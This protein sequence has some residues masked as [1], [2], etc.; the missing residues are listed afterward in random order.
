M[1]RASAGGEARLGSRG[2]TLAN[3]G[4]VR[5]LERYAKNDSVV[6]GQRLIRNMSEVD[7]RLDLGV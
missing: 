2:F 3:V 1:L 5:A 7:Q 6:H 4:A